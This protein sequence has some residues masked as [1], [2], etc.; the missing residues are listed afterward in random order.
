M[1]A[2]IL[3]AF[4]A[5]SILVTRSKAEIEAKGLRFILIEGAE[6]LPQRLREAHGEIRPGS[7]MSRSG[8]K[9]ALKERVA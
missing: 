2:E 6:S 8:F 4:R 9:M 7:N 1:D 3:S 5:G